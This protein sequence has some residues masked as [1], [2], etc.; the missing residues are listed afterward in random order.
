MNRCGETTI[1]NKLYNNN[2]FLIIYWKT[3]FPG[4]M[5]EIA[6]NIAH[7]H[8]TNL[9]S[10]QVFAEHKLLFCFMAHNIESKF[11]K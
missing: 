7:I 10:Q 8:C 9:Y 6:N 4:K 5:S 11:N 2:N 3:Q 1:L